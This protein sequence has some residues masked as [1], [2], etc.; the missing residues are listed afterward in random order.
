MVLG[1]LD[2]FGDGR[3]Q[4]PEIWTKEMREKQTPKT[5]IIPSVLKVVV[6]TVVP[7]LKERALLL[8]LY[9]QHFENGPAYKLTLHQAHRLAEELC[10]QGILTSQHGEQSVPA[11]LGKAGRTS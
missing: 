7:I 4:R 2:T 5:I 10:R 3:E 1:L 6:T 8:R 11:R 9:G